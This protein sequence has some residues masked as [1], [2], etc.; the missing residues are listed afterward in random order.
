[1][2]AYL[3]FGLFI[4]VLLLLLTTGTPVGVSLGMIGILVTLIFGDVSQLGRLAHTAFSRAG[5]FVFLVIP[6]FVFMGAVLAEGRIG[7][8]LYTCAQRWLGRL[9]GALAIATVFAA[10]AFGS[11]CGSSPVTA[12]TIG[13]ISVPEMIKRGYDKRLALGATAAGGTLGIM[14]PPSIAFIVYGIVTETSIGKLFIA[15]ILPGILLAFTLSATVV[16]VVTFRPHMAPRV[17]T[18]SWGQRFASLSGI[19]PAAV[20]CFAVL[21]SIY[22]GIATPSESA[23]VGALGSLILALGMNR[24]SKK[25]LV[26]VMLR[27]VTT[28]SMIMLILVGRPVRFLHPQPVRNCPGHGHRPDQPA[29]RP[30]GRNGADKCVPVDFRH[31]S[32]PAQHRRHHSAGLLP[33]GGPTRL[34]P[35]LVRRHH[36]A[37]SRTGRHQPAGGFQP[38]CSQRRG[39]GSGPEERYRRFHVVHNSVG[40]GHGRPV[41]LPADRAVAAVADEFLTSNPDL[42]VRRRGAAQAVSER[43]DGIRMG[44]HLHGRTAIVTGSGHGIGKAVALALANEGAAVV[45]NARRADMAEAVA[46]EIREAGGRAAAF[47]CDVSDFQA[48]GGLIEAAINTFG[49]LDIL[50]NNAGNMASQRNLAHDRSGVGFRCH[51]PSEGHL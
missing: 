31:V 28:S 45:T 23:A 1:M 2:E 18:A 29:H 4:I 38:F 24:L 22:F 11:I 37:Q 12:R 36:D 7:Q 42:A 15:G 9:P 30:L 33:H 34:R 21:G 20:L 6:L 5:D 17:R 8:D 32:G 41:S 27:T 43:E 48:T 16:V 3:L 35:D 50:V 25:R 19:W 13:A 10:A 26:G 39:A 49:R 44:N 51:R 46:D 47:P 40:S 14:I